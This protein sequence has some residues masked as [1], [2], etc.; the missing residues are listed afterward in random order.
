MYR[1]YLV[2]A[3]CVF[4][5]IV[6]FAPIF[7]ISVFLK[8]IGAQF[9]WTRTEVAAGGALAMLSVAVASPFVG[10]IIDRTGPRRLVTWGGLAFASAISLLALLPPVYPAYLAACLLIGVTGA[11]V[12]P[13]S[14]LSFIA[15][16]FDRHL[17]FALGVAMIG[18]GIGLAL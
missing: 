11:C 15:R 5:L 16:W 14:Y 2:L 1:A 9:G 8:P 17:G 13:L 12:T 3:A 7:N 4:G 10:R 6:S 18:V